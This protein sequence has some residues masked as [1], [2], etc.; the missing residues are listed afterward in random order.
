MWL[1]L[2]HQPRNA[3]GGSIHASIC[4]LAVAQADSGGAA[5]AAYAQIF[6]SPAS[7]GAASALLEPAAE[8]EEAAPNKKRKADEPPP[9]AAGGL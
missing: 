2:P 3:A 7:Q 1:V 6:L 8:E 9:A 4:A 5:W